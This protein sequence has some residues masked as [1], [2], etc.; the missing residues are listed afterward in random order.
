MVLFL[1]VIFYLKKLVYY[2]LLQSSYSVIY[3]TYDIVES[4]TWI[5]SLNF[6]KQ[7]LTIIFF[8][9]HCTFTVRW[10][11]KILFKI[12]LG[13]WNL[14]C[15]KIYP[16]QKNGWNSNCIRNSMLTFLNVNKKWKQ[17]F[18]FQIYDPSNLHLTNEIHVWV[19]LQPD[20]HI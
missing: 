12:K 10:Q 13:K 9:I 17:G 19:Q 5:Q 18:V 3:Y 4:C 7:I 1:F 11:M 15:Y 20:S 14:V 16:K 2:I 6:W 8:V